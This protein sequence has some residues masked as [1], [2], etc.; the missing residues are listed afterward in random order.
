[1]YRETSPYERKLRREVRVRHEE[2]IF[3]R[4]SVGNV[5][6]SITEPDIHQPVSRWQIRGRNA[7]DINRAS[8][9]PTINSEIIS[10][11]I[12]NRLSERAGTG[13]PIKR[14]FLADERYLS[15]LASTTIAEISRGLSI[16][17]GIPTVS[18]LVPAKI[19]IFL[20]P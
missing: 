4:D 10:E 14:R 7:G 2:H 8:T 3:R 9:L 17:R 19:T 1:M 13:K 20:C 15:C 5:S 6:T 12:A 11:R 18:F 16:G